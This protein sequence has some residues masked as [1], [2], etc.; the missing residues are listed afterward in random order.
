MVLIFAILL[1]KIIISHP[2]LWECWFLNFINAQLEWN[3]RTMVLIYDK[4]SVIYLHIS[5]SPN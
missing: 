3:W 5:D 2:N 1:L 4:M